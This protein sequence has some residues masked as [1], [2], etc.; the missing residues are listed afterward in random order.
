MIAGTLGAVAVVLVAGRQDWW[1]RIVYFAFFGGL[2]WSFG[3]TMSYGQVIAY[4]HC[5]HLPSQVYGFACLFVIGFLW[6]AMGGAGTAV[7]A[8]LDR[9]RLT[10]LIP[11]IIAVFVAWTVMDIVMLAMQVNDG[12][13]RHEHYLY[14]YD[15][16]WV[17]AM[18][19]IEAVLIYAAVRGRIC[20]GTSLVL[21]CSIG[22]WIGFLLL[23]VQYGLR[24]TPPRGDSWAG[25]LGM[26]L[27]LFAFCIRHRLW[28]VLLAGLISGVVG[29]LGFATAQAL[30]LVGLK[31]GLT[32]NWH[33]VME[34][35]YGFINGVGIALAMGTLAS[36]TPSLTEVPE[37]PRPD[38]PESV[39]KA[40]LGTPR[41]E[42]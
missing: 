15:T 22:W 6:A 17:A 42:P 9:K 33:S 35:T 8:C 34:Q 2:G 30:K 5:G 26:T 7:V 1:R 3:G 14:W 10:E 38:V 39:V 11:P 32:T 4:T 13:F 18:L 40:R 27:G 31:T 25:A 36:K 28:P 29:G 23:V 16:D 20:L 41:A 21:Y 12:E 19:A 24:M 37:T